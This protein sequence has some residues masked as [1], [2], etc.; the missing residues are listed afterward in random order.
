[1]SFEESLRRITNNMED[2]LG[3]ALVGMDGIVVEEHKRDLLLDLDSLSAEYC[4]LIK[5]LGKTADSQSMGIMQELSVVADK[6]TIILKRINEEYFLLLV[7]GSDGNFGK[8]RFL[9]R[10]EMYYLEKEL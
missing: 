6:S 1:M 9:M 5:N 7:V 3:V 10:R 2:S 8:G 4:S